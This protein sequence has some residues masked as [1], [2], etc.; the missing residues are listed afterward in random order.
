MDG[1]FD[2]WDGLLPLLEDPIDAPPGALADI[3]RVWAAHDG[4]WLYLS[5][6][7]AGLVNVQAMRGTLHLVLD[8]DGDPRTGGD[9]FGLP[10]AEW[11][12]DLS[13]QDRPQPGGYGAGFALRPVGPE[14]IGPYTSS[15]DAR[16]TG[17]PTHAS[18]R[19]EIR[20]AREASTGAEGYGGLGSSVRA[21]WVSTRGEVVL[22]ETEVFAVELNHP[23]GPEP[24]PMNPGPLQRIPGTLRVAHWN[25]AEGRFRNPEGH[26]AVLAALRPDVVLL[27]EV[28]EEVDRAALAAFFG[29]P[30]LARLGSWSFVISRAGGR[31]KTVVAARDRAIR[32]EASM[33]RV[34]YDGGEI[35]GLAEAWG[36]AGADFLAREGEIGMSATGAWVE[37]DGR[38]ILLVPFDLQSAGYLDSPQD[39]LRVVQS[40]TLVRHVLRALEARP[41]GP[42]PAAVVLGGDL[43]L[44]GGTT[45][46]DRLIAGLDRAGLD[47]RAAELR[48]LGTASHT[49]WRDSRGGPF[50]PGILDMTLYSASL[51]KQASGFVFATEDLD[52]ATLESLGLEREASAL[53]SDH[54]VLVTDLA[55]TPSSRGPGP[56]R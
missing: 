52:D 35:A 13:R 8:A 39:R 7:V 36:T 9:A 10:G 46:L 44:V 50:A 29:H 37:F 2:D 43:N 6:E 19:F 17:V 41:P 24:I 47:L 1:R 14:G 40:E 26:A 21:R 23:P 33:V 11:V 45:P 4:A 20:L 25:V 34:D 12:L 5:L 27:D 49:T 42:P 53:A 15:Y 16:V 28:Y 54:L 56:P 51:L 30:S 22:D 55:T 38:E 3:T 31:Q 48:R 18:R 32:Q